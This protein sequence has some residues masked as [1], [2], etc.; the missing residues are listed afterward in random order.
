MAKEL[1]KASADLK[2]IPE[3]F[4]E[5]M[6]D[7]AEIM[8]EREAEVAKEIPSAEEKKPSVEEKKED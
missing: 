6:A 5:G 1:G 8:K 3:A 4:N 2:Q 7:G